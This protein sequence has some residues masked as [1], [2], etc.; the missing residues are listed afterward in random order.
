VYTARLGEGH[1]KSRFAANGLAALKPP[2][3]AAA[4]TSGVAPKVNDEKQASARDTVPPPP[5]QVPAAK[6]APAKAATAKA[7]VL[8]PPARNPPPAAARNDTR[9]AGAAPE[10]QQAANRPRP[11]F[12]CAKARSV[13]E[14]LICGD[15]QLAQLD[16]ELGSLYARAKSGARDPAAFKR[17]SDEEWLQREQTCRDRQCL[18]AW[19][20]H[21]RADL[22]DELEAQRT[23]DDSASAHQLSR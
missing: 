1:E 11:S 9:V 5:V 23:G 2:Q 3:V 15:A 22:V 19:Y 4:A 20:A 7:E 17:L 8:Q 12:E 13:P 16:R 18:L 6:A 10:R 14:R 21:R